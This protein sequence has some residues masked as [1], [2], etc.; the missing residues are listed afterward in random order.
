M[1]KILLG[2]I[3]SQTHLVLMKLLGSWF[4]H[5]LIPCAL[6]IFLSET[7][8]TFFHHALPLTTVIA[9]VVP[10]VLNTCSNP[11][12]TLTAS[13]PSLPAVL[14][15]S[16]EKLDTRYFMHITS[17][18]HNTPKCYCRWRSH[19]SRGLATCSFHAAKSDESRLS[20]QILLT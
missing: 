18:H 14:L 1:V 6:S 13:Q 2:F 17:S 19:I 20:S 16:V 10:S 7:T 11:L 4:Q 8:V 5:P 15:R 12:Q 9:N 3:F